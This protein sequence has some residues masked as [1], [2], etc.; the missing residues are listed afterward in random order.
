[1]DIEPNLSAGQTDV[2][3]PVA[4]VLP[5]NAS[6]VA[7]GTVKEDYMGE[8][9]VS[10]I[11]MCDEDNTVALSPSKQGGRSRSYTGYFYYRLPT[12]ACNSPRE[13]MK[14]T[15]IYALT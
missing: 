2:S 3:I 9:S 8:E 14:V 6:S 13:Y 1:M 5:S 10:L 4:M 15:G 11:D 12:V 7:L